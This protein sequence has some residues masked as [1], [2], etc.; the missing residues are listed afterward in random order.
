MGGMRNLY[1]LFD[2]KPEEGR[3]FQRYRSRWGILSCLQMGYDV[4]D[5]I[6]LGQDRVQCRAFMGT[7]TNLQVSYNVAYFP[8]ELIEYGLVKG[9]SIT[10]D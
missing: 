7:G 3:P 8:G 10:R 4:T 6:C 9:D 2:A 5:R 1:K